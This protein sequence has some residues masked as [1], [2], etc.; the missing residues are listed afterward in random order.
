MKIGKPKNEQYS[1]S[2][3]V[4]NAFFRLYIDIK[5]NKNQIKKWVNESKNKFSA[6]LASYS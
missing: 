6:T 3:V 5:G 1:K 4:H 2:F